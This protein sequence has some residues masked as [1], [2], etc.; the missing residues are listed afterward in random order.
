MN[1]YHYCS[2]AT[3]LS[4]IST[5]SV[6]ASG[7]SLSNDAMEGQWIRQILSNYCDQRKLLPYEKERLLSSLDTV[8]KLLVFGGFCMSAKADLL[9]QWRGYA[10][11]GAGVCIGFSK[12][13]ITD[14]C[15]ENFDSGGVHC[16]L[17]KV[18]YDPDRQNELVA[19]EAEEIFTLISKGALST[20]SLL[21]ME[22]ATE[23]EERKANYFRLSNRVLTLFPHIYT[24]KNPAFAEEEEWRLISMMLMNPDTAHNKTK[25]GFY[26]HEAEFRAAA[27]R[28]VPYKSI[29]L[30]Q[31]SRSAINEVIIGPK[32]LTPDTVIKSALVRYGWQDVQIRRSSASYR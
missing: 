7:L 20:P 19:T 8:T 1:L 11:N 30:E 10:D 31:L 16:H 15:A 28:I 9:S 25:S 29:S 12:D 6:W 13:Y 14:L 22:T 26:T 24:L 5:R 4:I 2:N 21:S 27:D 17:A 32:N 18:I 23:E 3:F